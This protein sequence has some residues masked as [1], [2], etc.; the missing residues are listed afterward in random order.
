MSFR[1]VTLPNA[2]RRCIVLHFR[3]P[4]NHLNF[5]S[6]ASCAAADPRLKDIGSVIQND[7]AALRERYDVPKHPIILAHGLLGFDEMHLLGNNIPGIQYWRGIREAL[8]KA[9]IEVIT[10][11]VPPSGSLERRAQRLAETIEEK[12]NGKSVNIIA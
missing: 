10:A 2:T 3:N 1:L 12:A 6:S 7:F 11:T 9:G 8:S 5:S 4:P